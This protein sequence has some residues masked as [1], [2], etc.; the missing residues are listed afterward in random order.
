MTRP[1]FTFW[2]CVTRFSQDRGR[3]GCSRPVKLCSLQ[4]ALGARPEADPTGVPSQGPGSH[5]GPGGQAA[6][7]FYKAKQH[8]R[9]GQAASAVVCGNSHVNFAESMFFGDFEEKGQKTAPVT[10]CA[11]AVR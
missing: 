8:R 9:N 5:E 11:R 7:Q 6:L 4:S 3:A 10:E 1:R 2:F